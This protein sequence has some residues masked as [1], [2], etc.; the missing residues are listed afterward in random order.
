MITMRSF[1]KILITFDC[2]GSLLL[3]EL[4]LVGVSGATLAVVRRLLIAVAFFVA[5]CGLKNTG[6]VAAARRL[7]C[8]AACGIFLIRD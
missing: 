3:C 6:S 4:S 1:L 7:S 2:A 8:S 5:E